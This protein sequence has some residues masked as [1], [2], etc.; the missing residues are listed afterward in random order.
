MNTALQAEVEP[1]SAAIPRSEHDKILARLDSIKQYAKSLCL[2]AS[3]SLMPHEILGISMGS[4]ETPKPHR[5]AAP[6]HPLGSTPEVA[7]RE[8]T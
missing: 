1:G 5:A 2:A 3:N 6:L 7:M 4:T 8:A